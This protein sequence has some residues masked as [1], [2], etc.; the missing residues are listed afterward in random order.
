MVHSKRGDKQ[1][2]KNAAKEKSADSNKNKKR[3]MKLRKRAAIY[4]MHNIMKCGSPFI[5]ESE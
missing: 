2:D 1:I 4:L 5:R 3:G